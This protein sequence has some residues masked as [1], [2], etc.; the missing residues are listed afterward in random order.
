MNGMQDQKCSDNFEA[1]VAEKEF[2]AWLP[3]AKDK[4]TGIVLNFKP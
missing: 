2:L 4:H 3:F 1:V